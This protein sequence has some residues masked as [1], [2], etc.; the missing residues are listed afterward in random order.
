[1]ATLRNVAIAIL[2]PAGHA[3]IAAA[4]RYH[5]RDATRTLATLRLIPP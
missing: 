5:A 4:C 1:M 2:K 3:D